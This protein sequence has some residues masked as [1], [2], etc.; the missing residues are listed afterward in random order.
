MVKRLPF[1]ISVI[2]ICANAFAQVVDNFS[3]GDFTNN[4]SWSGTTADFI[5][6]GSQQLQLN[7][8]VAAT[9]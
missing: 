3:D 5:V 2:L 7:N 8:T 4:P 9:S 6:N 1:L